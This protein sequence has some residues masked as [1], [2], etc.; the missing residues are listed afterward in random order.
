[1]SSKLSKDRSS[2]CS[3]TFADGRRCRTPRC[4]THAYL[5]YSHAR[6]EAQTLTAQQNGR[7]IASWIPTGYLSACDLT[8]ALAQLFRGTVQGVIDPRTATALGYLGQTIFQGMHL[9]QA[10]YID[11]FGA[12]EWR[13]TIRASS[14]APREPEVREPGTAGPGGESA[15]ESA[16]VNAPID[17]KPEAPSVAS[18][19]ASS[20][21][22][23][24]PRKTQ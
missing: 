22:T 21:T 4:S 9:A 2:L 5:C 23:N 3:F 12:R 19:R 13:D 11:A 15:P 8:A 18:P 20:P 17:I 6:A 1:M 7:A 10:E 16:A 14:A 24:Q